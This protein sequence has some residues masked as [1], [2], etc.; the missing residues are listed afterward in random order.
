LKY[1]LQLSVFI[2]SGVVFGS[3]NQA[4]A[5]SSPAVHVFAD[6]DKF[7]LVIHRPVYLVIVAGAQVYHH[8]LVSKE[9]HHCDGVI[10]LVH[11]IKIRNL[12]DINQVDDD[13]VLYFLST[14]EEHFV[15]LHAGGI[16]VVAESDDDQP[17]FFV[18]NRL[19]DIPARFQ[20]WQHEGHV[21]TCLI[22]DK[23]LLLTAARL[24]IFKI[25]I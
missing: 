9:K 21:P 5:L 15:H 23:F 20:V 25:K 11:S 3:Y 4:L 1:H 10:Q 12:A 8:M 13:P 24:I 2:F 22:S 18:K 17:F 7:L 6:V 16:S 19:V 14:L